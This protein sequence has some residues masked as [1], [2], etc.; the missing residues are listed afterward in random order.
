MVTGGWS[1][2]LRAYGSSR[3]ALL[4]GEDVIVSGSVKNE[5]LRIGTAY[6]V[7]LLADAYKHESPV[8]DTNRDLD[9]N[10]KRALR[11]VD[12]PVSGLREFAVHWSIPDSV[13]QRPLD[14]RLQVLNP[15]SLFSGPKPH[16]FHDTGWRGAFEVLALPEPGGSGPCVFLSYSWD[17]EKHRGWVS[18]FADELRK[19]GARV[20][21]D[22]QDLFAGTEIT[23][24][25]ET[26]LKT[27]DVTILVCTETYTR[28]A[29]SR[30]GGVGLETVIGSAL[31]FHSSEKDNFIPVVRNN[32][33]PPSQKL[34]TYLGSTRYV[35][36]EGDQ[37]NGEPMQD[38]LRSIRALHAKRVIA[39]AQ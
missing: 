26:A 12:I 25:I 2:S 10:A 36:M 38:L 4:P 35:D 18:Q 27:A 29:N 15:H 28:K 9:E 31:Y 33:L 32:N 3:H 20:I 8:F 16:C 21:L 11:L 37:W 24:F 39:K 22:R 7:V 1:F 13:S 19:H 23:R 30:E 14:A 34:P 17:T 6:V 5:G